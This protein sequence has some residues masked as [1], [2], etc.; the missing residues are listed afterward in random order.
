MSTRLRIISH[1]RSTRGVLL[2]LL[3]LGREFISDSGRKRK[4]GEVTGVATHESQKALR[5]S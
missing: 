3:L 2:H 5:D 1:F 4:T